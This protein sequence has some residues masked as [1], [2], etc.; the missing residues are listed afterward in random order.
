MLK[1]IHISDSHLGCADL[2]AVNDAGFNIRE[3]D[4]YDAF[5]Q[6]V[7]II[8][9][10]KP[11]FVLH[12]GDLFHRASPSN[13]SIIFAAKELKRIT[14]S[15]IPFYMIAG[16]HDYPKT[17]NTAPIHELLL[18]NEKLNISFDEKYTV[19]E[20]P[21]FILHMLPHINND[22]RFTTATDAI[23]VSGKN[24]KPEILAMHLSLGD[25]HM[26]ELGERV[27]P[28]EK[29]G[30]LK[31]FDYVA[32]GHWHKFKKI[33]KYG[34]VWYAGST[35]RTSASQTG[36]PMGVVRVMIENGT[37]SAELLPVK[38]REWHIIIIENCASKGAEAILNELAEKIK[39]DSENFTEDKIFHITLLDTGSFRPVTDSDIEKL[40]PGALSVQV[41]AYKTDTSGMFIADEEKTDLRGS[42]GEILKSEFTNES[43]LQAANT[44]IGKLWEKIEAE[45]SDAGN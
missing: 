19:F 44:I 15:G 3:N 20:E 37:T 27:F 11:D 2:D 43:E 9:G 8:I 45:E 26:E 7:D 1:F 42:L 22:E 13:R 40:C 18:M 41:R 4:F 23:R 36:Y 39:N 6:A 24:R 10:E 5:S 16:N 30:I 12:T 34:N 38:L 32:M 28:V 33:D 17:I 14:D 35:E 25:Y 21:G 31:Q 29:T